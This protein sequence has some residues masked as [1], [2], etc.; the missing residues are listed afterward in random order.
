MR[1]AQTMLGRAQAPVVRSIQRR[2][3]ASG[4]RHLS[5]AEAFACISQQ[6]EFLAVPPILV[7]EGA[8]TMDQCRE[9]L[10]VRA[11]RSYLDAGTWGTM[12]VGM[13]Y[14]MAAALQQPDRCVVAIEGDSAFG[15]SA[16]EVET[17]CRY[18]LHVIVLVFNN[19]GVYGASRHPPASSSEPAVT[20]LTPGVRY[21]LLMEAS[22]GHGYHAD[23]KVKLSAALARSLATQ[24]PALIN[25]V[26]DPADG[27]E[28]GSAGSALSH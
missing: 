5:Y 23:S 24:S 7:S 17:I 15:F 8:N 20:D 3:D 21:D 13:G 25:V 28:N 9:L 11:P 14:A 4:P 18:R 16:M 22:G 12:G 1:Y 6:L 19:S 26:I 27:T 2:W 10:S